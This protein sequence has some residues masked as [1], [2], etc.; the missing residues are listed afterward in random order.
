MRDAVPDLEPHTPMLEVKYAARSEG[1]VR[2]E[3]PVALGPGKAFAKHR[4]LQCRIGE[5]ESREYTVNVSSVERG[6]R[7]PSYPLKPRRYDRARYSL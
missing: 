1:L 2:E 4:V 7:S 5:T 6:P 3:F